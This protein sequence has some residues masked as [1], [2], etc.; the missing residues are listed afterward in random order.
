MRTL[1]HRIFLHILLLALLAG[2]AGPS[3]VLPEPTQ[4]P[5]QVPTQVPA[6]TPNL[7]AYE[8][9]EYPNLFDEML[10]K[11][12]AEVQA[13]IEAAFQQLFYGDD[14]SE[15]VYY[16]VGSD[17]A[18]LL[19]TGNDDVRSEGMS[20]GMMIAVQ[21]NKK[22]EFDRIWKWTKTYMYQTD[23][24]YKGYFAWHCKPDGTQLAANPASDGEI[25]FVMALFFADA[26]WGSG[27]GIFNYRAEAQ[28]ILDVA[29]N[30]KELGGNLATNLFDPQTKQVVF[31]PQ[32]GNN[33]KF[34][35]ASY[36]MPHFYELWARWADKNND[37]WAEAVIASREFLPT[38]VHPETGLAPN[39][40]YFDGRPYNDEYHGQFRYDAFRVGANI[41]MDYVWFHP[42][43]WYV[44]QA[45]RQLSFFASQGID[46]YVAEYS[47]D[48]QPLA[49]HRATGLIATNAV[50]AHAADP[51]IGQPFVQALWDATAPTGTYRYYDGL[52][53]LMGLLQTSGN[54]RIY[55]PGVAPRA[56]AP[57]ET[58][59]VIQGKFAPATGQALLI[60]GPDAAGVN[61]YFDKLVT[62]PG[63]VNVELSLQSLD[64][65]SLEALVRKFP[66]STLS[67]GLSVSGLVDSIVAGEADAQ[68]SELLDAL[69]A[70]PRPVFLRI[71]PEFDLAANGFEP[72][73]YVAAWQ[74]IHNE[75]QARGS[76]N[77]ALVWHSAAD[78]ESPFGGHPAEDWYPGD[79]FVDWVAISHSSQ[80]VVCDRQSIESMMQF[81]REHDK[82]VMMVA[83]P[84]EGQTDVP[85]GFVRAN[86]DVIRALLY[87]NT[88]PGFFDAPQFLSDWKTEIG[89]RFWLRGGPSLFDT[90]ND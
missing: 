47:L 37:F 21:M 10:G 3:P 64:L 16:P 54:F 75:I 24:G 70:Y 34:T 51:E 13:K 73:S 38:A 22:E 11:S 69:E 42:S 15:R 33:S 77:V 35:D 45:N 50:L 43:D 6:K 59:R 44:E 36:H 8:S 1:F 68:I 49:G 83:I 84:F 81:A 86:N 17:M 2:C 65:E 9:G 53:Y 90:L 71:G 85:F 29:L 89:D 19:D 5:T 20:Y 66:N 27:E 87:F 56:E 26:R 79:E 57:L 30:A 4:M 60:L 12:D 58:P 41:G 55:E 61:A 48:G 31:V 62:A 88:T 52:L 76:E 74:T 39:Y 40:S 63:G 23:G 80:S 67:V 72:G 28:A 82:P 14:V 46:D 32:L 18:Y 25:W 78:C 7:G